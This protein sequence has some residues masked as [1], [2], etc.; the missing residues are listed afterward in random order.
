MQRAKSAAFA[1]VCYTLPTYTIMV[2]KSTS[3]LKLRFS[4]FFDVS[5]AAIR[6]HGA[7][8]ISLVTDLPL[9]LFLF[10]FVILSAAKDLSSLFPLAGPEKPLALVPF[11]PVILS[12]G[13]LFAFECA[14][15]SSIRVRPRCNKRRTLRLVV[16]VPVRSSYLETRQFQV[17]SFIGSQAIPLVR[18]PGR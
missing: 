8:N 3:N 1:F 4:D 7:F 16:I 13:S 10:S 18:L 11:P 12:E 6:E 15:E 17:S 9:A 2:P 5:P 14:S